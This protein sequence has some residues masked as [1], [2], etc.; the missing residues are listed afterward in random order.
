M[1]S[2]RE[3][4]RIQR[5][6]LR[7]DIGRAP[8]GSGL[9]FSARRLD[10]EQ[11]LASRTSTRSV[12]STPRHR[13]TTQMTGTKPLIVD[14]VENAIQ[15]LSELGQEIVAPIA[16]SM[17]HTVRLFAAAHSWSMA[18]HN[19]FA[20]W[21]TASLGHDVLWLVLDPLIPIDRACPNVRRLRLSRHTTAQGWKIDDELPVEIRTL[22]RSTDVGLVDDVAVS[23]MTIRHV[24]DLVSRET[25]RVKKV[26]VA[27]SAD[28][29]ERSSER[30]RSCAPWAR[31]AAGNW[32]AVHMRD[33][34]PLL[35]FAGRRNGHIRSIST[36]LG[37]VEIAVPV[38]SFAGGVWGQLVVD[39]N[40]R[41]SIDS[42]TRLV[43][44]RFSDFIGR[45]ATI[46]D[47]PLLGP[48]VRPA[49][50]RPERAT[51]NSTLESVML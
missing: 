10:S 32:D 40:L 11:L 17:R 19:A 25:G 43:I 7:Y 41:H 2:S 15:N 42:A 24:T 50:R 45:Q 44:R 12:S 48:H 35:P 36:E 6:D 46:A 3:Y 30:D 49:L 16:Q 28:G 20:E 14:D 9:L 5:G 31:F 51:A 23:G 21:A 4:D 39:S 27:A 34:C 22:V 8:F 18:S 13:A 1:S 38:A 26:I 33:T 29:A 37:P 47:I